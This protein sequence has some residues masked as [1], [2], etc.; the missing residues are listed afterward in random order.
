MASFKFKY[1]FHIKPYNLEAYW[2]RFQELLVYLC[3][4]GEMISSTRDIINDKIR[5]YLLQARKDSAQGN[6]APPGY[7]IVKGDW[8]DGELFVP[9][10]LNIN[11][12]GGVLQH[13]RR[14]HA[15]N[16]NEPDLADLEDKVLK[17]KMECLHSEYFNADIMGMI[18][19]S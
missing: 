16:L 2:L 15:L 11:N 8:K 5:P 4:S 18:N 19:G 13:A 7:L 10:G 12:K 3:V 14:V 17:A 6:F 9:P 1:P